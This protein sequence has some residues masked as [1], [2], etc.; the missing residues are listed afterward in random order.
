MRLAKLLWRLYGRY[1]R[2]LILLTVLG[3]AGGVL[4]SF[5]VTMLIPLLSHVLQESLPEVGSLS[6]YFNT[7]FRFFGF[8]MHLRYLLP[9]IAF[10]FVFRAVVLFVSEYCRARITTEYERTKR[11]DLYQA[12]LRSSWPRLLQQKLGSAENTIMVDVGKTTKLISDI[13][14]MQLQF[15]TAIIY[16]VAAFLVSPGITLATAIAGALF[17]LFSQPVFSRIRALAAQNLLLNKTIAHDI[18]ESV[19]GLKAIKAMGEEHTVMSRMGR[20]FDDYRNM[21]LRQ[22]VMAALLAVSSQPVSIIFVLGVFAV[23]FLQPGFSLAAFAIV[24]FLIQRIFLYVDRIQRALSTIGEALPYSASVVRFEEAFAAEREHA[25]EGRPF[26]FDREIAF[27]KVSFSYKPNVPVLRSVSFALK[28]GDMLAI[29]GPSGVGKT[30][31]AD[32]LLRLLRPASGEIEIDGAPLGDVSLAQWRGHAGYVS[33]DPFLL[34][35]TI[36][37]NVAFYDER[38]RKEDVERALKD[39]ALWD[40]VKNLPQGFNTPVGERGVSFSAG[41]RQRITLARALARR[42]ALL[43]LDEATSALDVESEQA[44]LQTLERLRGEMTIVVIAHR[45]STIRRVDKLLVLEKGRVAEYGAPQ[46]LLKDK[47]SRFYKLHRIQA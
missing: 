14:W 27:N 47:D 23:A 36:Y 37:N 25:E 35:D 34:N 28:K 22:G 33:Q 30:T 18:N 9:F 7:L 6:R 42:P 26:S 15:T 1:K 45:L 20:I 32:L 3:F 19:L 40:M 29:I 44:I 17:L 24:V 21:R 13:T 16:A 12:L 10:I 4:E 11:R 41:Q 5:G 8:G 39:A 2:S 46:E 43:I 38:I 31:V